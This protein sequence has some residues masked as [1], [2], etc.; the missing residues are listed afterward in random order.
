MTVAALSWQLS[1]TSNNSDPLLIKDA[2]GT[3]FTLPHFT[4]LQSPTPCEITNVLLDAVYLS[5][6]EHSLVINQIASFS[7]SSFDALP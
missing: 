5:N 7:H 2:S 4:S 3:T 6:A 1:N